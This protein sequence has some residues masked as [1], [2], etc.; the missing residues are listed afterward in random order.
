MTDAKDED[1]VRSNKRSHSD[2]AGQ[3]ESGE[4]LQTSEAHSNFFP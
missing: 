3:N 4:L 1:D 2:F